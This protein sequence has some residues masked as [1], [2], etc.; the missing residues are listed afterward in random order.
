MIFLDLHKVY[1]SLDRS[2]CLEILEGYGVGPQARQILQ[3]YWRRLTMVA[4]VGGYYGT[5]FQGARGVTQVDPLSPTI[6]NVVVDVVV[7]NWVTV[8]I[9]GAEDW[10]KSGQEGRHQADLFYVGNGMVV[11]SD[12]AG[13]MVHSTIWLSCLIGWACGPM[14]GRQ[15]AWS[16]VPAKRRGISWWRRTGDGSRVRAPPT[17][18]TRRDGFTAGS[19]GR[20]WWQDLWRVT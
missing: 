11:S 14:L 1:D 2:R 7:R 17:G 20:R 19:A 5:A 6:F 4:R 8:V 12:P 3:T 15:S 13:Y 9:A 18:S 10:G 16:A